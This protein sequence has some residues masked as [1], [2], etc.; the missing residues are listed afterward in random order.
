MLA[1]TQRF[2][3]RAAVWLSLL[4]LGCSSGATG[5]PDARELPEVAD[6]GPHDT[7]DGGE[8]ERRDAATEEA[9]AHDA[10]ADAPADGAVDASCAD[11]KGGAL[12]TFSIGA[13]SLRVWSTNAKFNNDAF[14]AAAQGALVTPVFGN[15]VEG[16]DCDGQWTWHP[17]AENV[18]FGEASNETCAGLPSEIEAD[19]AHWLNGVDRYCPS[20]VLVASFQS[21]GM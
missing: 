19:K 4:M 2:P 16:V 20:K 5:S 14:L 17:D 1:K 13:E 7:R 18:S 11:R 12:I 3:V 8:N 10:G 6:G 9:S 15:L 21:A